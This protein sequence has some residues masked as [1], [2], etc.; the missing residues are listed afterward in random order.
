M[1]RRLHLLVLA[2]LIS[3]GL[4]CGTSRAD[5]EAD[6]LKKFQSQNKTVAEKLKEEASRLL[7]PSGSSGPLAKNDLATIQALLARLQ[8]DVSLP[9]EERTGL[10]RKLQDR[11]RA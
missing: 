7:N 1:L 9:R 10:I 5:S 11:A 2:A 3:L 8:D 4:P 6:L